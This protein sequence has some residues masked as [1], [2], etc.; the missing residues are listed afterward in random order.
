MSYIKQAPSAV[1]MVRPH[2][3]TSNPQTMLDNTF[4]STC[5]SQNQSQHAFDEVTNAVKLL[6]NEGVTVHLF[7]DEHTHTPD[8]VFP[9]NWFSTHQSGELVMYPMY[10]E[11]RR[12]EYRKDI[13]DF[14]TN[15]YK[16]LSVTDYSFLAKENAFLEGTGSLVIDH[17]HKLAYAVESKRTTKTVVNTVCEQLKLKPVVFNA[18]DKQGTAV[19]HTNVLMCVATEFAMISLDMVPNSQHKQ[20]TNHFI[21]SHLEVINLTNEQISSFC[22]NAI[23]LQGTNGRILALSQTAFNA[24]TTE[25]KAAI[26]KTAKLVPLP[27]PTIESAGGSVR[28]M[29][30]GIH[31]QSK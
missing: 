14:L 17:P 29:I 31:L 27:I 23:E 10:A 4:Q 18:Y 20:L 25:Q 30:A 2:H 7:E 19:Y 26:Q 11:N 5:N 12:L 9:N 8:S 13:I 1:V 28:C 15:H 24:L 3:F 21:Q 22:G 6:Q 16:V